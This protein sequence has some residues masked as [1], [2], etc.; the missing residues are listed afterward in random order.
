[1]DV[2]RHIGATS[3]LPPHP[4]NERDER[5]GRTLSGCAS[6]D[7]VVTD[8]HA[9]GPIGPT[10]RR[11]RFSVTRALEWSVASELDRA[12]DVRV[13]E[14]TRVLKAEPIYA[15]MHTNDNDEERVNGA[16]L[17]V[18][19][20][21]GVSADKL[22]QLLQCHSAA[23]LLGQVDSSKFSDDPTWLPNAWLDIDVKPQAGN[24]AVTLNAN[25][26]AGNLQVL[27]RATA[28]A[29]AHRSWTAQ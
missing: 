24:F 25:T 12:D 18:R 28:F 29:D 9:L 20:P 14:S 26:V 6:T 4:L 27:H 3:N 19:A 1:V 11:N 22:A 7:V 10:G 8:E 17:V 23:V 13:L 21:E 16:T 2:D 15:Y 5:G